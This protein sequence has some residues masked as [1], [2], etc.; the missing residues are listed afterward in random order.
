MHLRCTRVV[1]ALKVLGL[2]IAT[3]TASV[4][5]AHQSPRSARRDAAVQ[6]VLRAVR[7]TNEICQADACEVVRVDSSIYVTSTILLVPARD[8]VAFSLRAEILSAMRPGIVRFVTDGP[9][10]GRQMPSDTAHATLGFSG[11]GPADADSVLVVVMAIPPKTVWA[12]WIYISLK[13]TG[14]TWSVERTWLRES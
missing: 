4:A 9:Y 1:L 14:S 11:E 10:D 8:S 13:W 5:C 7:W 6:T 2:S 3:L 12:T